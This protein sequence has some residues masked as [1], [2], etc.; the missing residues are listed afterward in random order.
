MLHDESAKFKARREKVSRRRKAE[1]SQNAGGVLDCLLLSAFC[2]LLSSVRLLADE[3]RHVE[4][5]G[6][7]GRARASRQVGG[8]RVARGRGESG[9]VGGRTSVRRLAV[10]ARGDDGDLHLVAQR[11]VNDRAGDDGGGVLPRLP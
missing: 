5:V 8:L 3:G 2:L 9:G 11:L 4:V 7:R 6:A 10:E 1:G